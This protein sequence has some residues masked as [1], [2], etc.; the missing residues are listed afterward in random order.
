MA[1]RDLRAATFWGAVV[2]LAMDTSSALTSV[3]LVSAGH[4]VAARTELDP[5]RHAEVLAPMINAVLDD[6]GVGGGDVDTLACGVGP[7]P[8][9]GLRVAIASARALGLA[10]SRPVVGVCSL[11]AMARAVLAAG[12]EGE[13]GVASDARRRE[14]YWAW[15]GGDGERQVGPQV[16]RPDEID[17]RLR[18]GAWCGHGALLH[19]ESFG[20]M[21]DDADDLLY[22]L[23]GWVGIRAGE[24]LAAHVEVTGAGAVLSAHGED[25]AGTSN[26]LTGLRLLLPEPLYLRRPDAV[27][28]APTPPLNVG[29]TP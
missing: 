25:G 28:A 20:S 17:E 8:Y 26:A 14:V 11:D 4:V 12:C 16:A 29:G 18:A 19:R 1:G 13:F 24:L 6:G 5:R 15:Y 10:W 21:L 2:I 9:T 22:P 23:A 7:G 3:A 27:E